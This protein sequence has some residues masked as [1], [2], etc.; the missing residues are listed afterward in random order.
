MPSIAAYIPA[1]YDSSRL[2]GKVLLKETGKYLIQHVY[3]RVLQARHIDQV[4]IAADDERIIEAAAEFGAPA[5]MTSLE[6]KSGTD[7]IAEVARNHNHEIIV[8]VQGDEPDIE[9]AA[10]DQLAQMMICHP[11]IRMGTLAVPINE[12]SR[13]QNPNVVKVVI[14]NAGDALYFSRSPVPHGGNHEK[15]L[16]QLPFQPLHHLGIYAF[17][18]EFLLEFVSLQQGRLEQ[19]EKLEQLR[20]LEHGHKIRVGL[21]EFANTGIDTPE[22]YEAFVARWKASQA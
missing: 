22:Q 12:I 2:P 3:E 15:P 17:R 14:D 4:I 18:R 11:E 6:H 5:F 20:A 10:V 7:R 21:L 8:N 1:R 19:L 9:P 13:Y 16:S